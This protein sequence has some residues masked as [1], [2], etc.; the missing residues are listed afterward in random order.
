V[1]IITASVATARD[2]R[3]GIGHADYQNNR[4]SLGHSSTAQARNAAEATAHCMHNPS[5]PIC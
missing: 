1:A 4:Q 2:P 3:Q 5:F